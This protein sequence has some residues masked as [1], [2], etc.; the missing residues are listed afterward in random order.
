MA[1]PTA[2]DA[3]RVLAALGPLPGR[4]ERP[5]LLVVSGLPGTGKSRLCRQVQA[6]TGAVLL[7]SDGLRRHLF[8][9]PDYSYLESRRLFA[10]IH[11]AID[12]LLADG[13]S[14]ILDATNLAERE[15]EPL[16]ATADRHR[17]R[18][19]LVQ[20][21]APPGVV[22]RRLEGRARGQ[23]PQDRSQ[24]DA[25]VHRR[26]AVSAEEIRR[27]HRVVDTS[28]DTKADVKAIVEEMESL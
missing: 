9:Q 7:E 26:M 13:R 15:R 4:R 8:G 17:A 10:A 18:L 6:R 5:T 16:Y 1:P 19:L 21:V 24:A 3:D 12:R 2:H 11:G 22:Q 27:P 25:E 23:D 14:A 20:V 28:Q